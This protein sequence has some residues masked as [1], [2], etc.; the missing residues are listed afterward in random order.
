[1]IFLLSNLTLDILDNEIRE[2]IILLLLNIKWK[3]MNNLSY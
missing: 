2:K 1:M 3:M